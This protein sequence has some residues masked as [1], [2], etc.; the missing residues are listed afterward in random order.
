MQCLFKIIRARQH[1]Q[2]QASFFFFKP[3]CRFL[4]QILS[5]SCSFWHYH[6]ANLENGEEE[7]KELSLMYTNNAAPK[8]GR[9]SPMWEMDG[10]NSANKSK[11]GWGENVILPY[12]FFFFQEGELKSFL[13]TAY[14]NDRIVIY[15]LVVIW[16]MFTPLPFP[17]SSFILIVCFTRLSCAPLGINSSCLSAPGY[18]HTWGCGE[19]DSVNVHTVYL[20]HYPAITLPNPRCLLFTP[21]CICD[22]SVFY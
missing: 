7:R 19:R 2:Q 17:I 11:L 22:F 8:S 15:H 1:I 18:Q 6:S 10:N 9:S 13:I 5:A 16:H 21:L 12:F 14:S 3:Q 4:Y 20:R